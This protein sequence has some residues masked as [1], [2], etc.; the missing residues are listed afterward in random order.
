MKIRFDDSL[1]ESRALLPSANRLQ[2]PFWAD[3]AGR[4]MAATATVDAGDGAGTVRD[5]RESRQA[6]RSQM[7]AAEAPLPNLLLVDGIG[8]VRL[9]SVVDSLSQGA[10]DKGF[11]LDEWK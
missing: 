7:R 5:P 4:I 10:D 8:P 1:T 3:R 9:R 11:N 2:R 6:R